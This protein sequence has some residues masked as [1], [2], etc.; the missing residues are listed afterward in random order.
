MSAKKKILVAG[1]LG[2]V[3]R[4]VVE[5][6]EQ[7]DAWEIV[8]LS[9]RSPDFDA[10]AHFL[11]VDLRD[12]QNCREVL[13]EVRDVQRIIYTA[14]YEKG[15]L[16]AG[17]LDPAHVDINLTMLRN[18]IDTI[19]EN[20]PNLEHVTVLQGT[21]AYGVHGGPSKV[22][23]KE[24]DSRYLPPTFYYAQEDWLRERS[25][26]HGW[27]WSALRPQLV[28]G[29]AL[30]S[31]N[32]GIAV[33]GVYAAVC[34]ELGLPLRFPGI[35]RIIEASDVRLIAKACLWAGDTPACGGEVFN[36]TNGD[37][38]VLQELWPR[39]AELF[40]MELG[41]PHPVPLQS[42]MADKEPVWN[43][44]V[45]KH[46]L[47]P[48]SY[49]DVVGSWEFADMVFG[50]GSHV[51]LGSGAATGAILVSTIKARQQGFHDCLDTEEAILW[52]LGEYQRRGVLP[53]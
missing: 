20:S 31:P 34:R 11:S 45:E 27:T 32:N 44:I 51:S 15:S 16:G 41:S 21:K 17:W 18:L 30:Q 50:G 25:K 36:I 5:H 53:R 23:G 4:A 1:A 24:S 49:M 29:Y 47:Q 46:G 35:P 3:G 10:R 14:L 2:L 8:C 40:G 7:D 6:L 9:R 28:T 12:E 43:R 19:E 22:P 42:V 13:G 48:H 38:V 37:V 52:W 39:I 26:G 33:I